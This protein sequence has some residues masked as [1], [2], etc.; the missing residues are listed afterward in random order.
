MHLFYSRKLQRLLTKNIVKLIDQVFNKFGEIKDDASPE[1]KIVRD[2]LRHLNGRITE[3]FNKSMS[4]H[5]DY[6]DDIRESVVGNRRV[7]AVKSALR[8][9]VKGQFLG[10]SKTGSITFIEPESVQNPRR[11]WEELKKKKNIW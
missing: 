9:R 5:S 7:L 4:Y 11:E 10:T 1:L 3:L 2:R 6:L 8:K